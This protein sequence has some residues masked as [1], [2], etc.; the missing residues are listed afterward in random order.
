MEPKA[1]TRRLA[2]ILAVDMVGFSRLI[3]ADKSGAVARLKARRSE[4]IDLAIDADFTPGEVIHRHD[5]DV[6][7]FG[8]LC[9]CMGNRVARQ[10]RDKNAHT[11]RGEAGLM[12]IS[13]VRKLLAAALCVVL[14]SCVA[15]RQSP[16]LMAA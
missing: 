2:A 8:V 5:D 4:F 1:D 14:V 16:E 12:I 6:R 3:E 11:R 9:M 10:C 13:K 15:V 7:F